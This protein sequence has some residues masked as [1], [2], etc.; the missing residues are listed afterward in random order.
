MGNGSN[1]GS[2]ADSDKSSKG[3]PTMQKVGLKL[4][5]YIKFIQIILINCIN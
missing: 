5:F 4:Y 3:S 2:E 1:Y